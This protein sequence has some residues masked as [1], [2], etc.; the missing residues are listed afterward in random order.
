MFCVSD[1]T[2]LDPNLVEGVKKY[3]LPVHLPIRLQHLSLPFR[4]L[5][6]ILIT[7]L[8]IGK[9]FWTMKEKVT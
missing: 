2:I 8:K 9:C 6:I 4:K 1:A 7:I 5:F 3:F